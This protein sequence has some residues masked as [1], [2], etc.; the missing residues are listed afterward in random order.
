MAVSVTHCVPQSQLHRP[1]HVRDTV[2]VGV[3][4]Q[5]L[6]GP[7]GT[8]VVLSQI[9]SGGGQPSLSSGHAF[10]AVTILVGHGLVWDGGVVVG[11]VRVG[12]QDSV[13]VS[14]V[15]YDPQPFGHAVSQGRCDVTVGV[16]GQFSFSPGIVVVLEE[17]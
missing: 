1:I 14:V 15:V 2:A 3:I 8:V 16:M 4:G 17:V 6:I 10:D 12:R 7:G 9:Q 13:A 11:D 5:S